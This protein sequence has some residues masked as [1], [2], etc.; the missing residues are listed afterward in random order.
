MFTNYVGELIQHD[1][2]Y[3]RWSP[4]IEEKLYL[5]TSL[6]DYSRFMLYDDLVE[7]ETSWSQL[8]HWK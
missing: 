2:S 3:H 4:Y 5:I 7:K 8:L 1:S 6:D